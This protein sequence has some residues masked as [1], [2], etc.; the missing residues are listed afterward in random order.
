MAGRGYSRIA[1]AA[2]A[3]AMLVVVAWWYWPQSRQPASPSPPSADTAF[4]TPKASHARPR[5]RGDPVRIDSRDAPGTGPDSIRCSQERLRRLQTRLDDLKHPATPDQV[6]QHVLLTIM[7][8]LQVPDETGPGRVARELDAARRRWPDNL[9]LAWLS[10]QHCREQSGCDHDAAL[11][12]LLALDPENAAA[13]LLAMQTARLRGDDAGYGRLLHRAAA[14]S[15]YD[16]RIGVIFLQARVLLASMPQPT[17]CVD[18]ANAVELTRLLGHAPTTDDWAVAGAS[19][20]ESALGLPAY[21]GLS[22]CN[23]S[24]QPLPVARRRDCIALLARVADGDTLLEQNLA[25]G[26]LI[27][28]TG[29]GPGHAQLRE[30]YRRLRWLWTQVPPSGSPDYSARIWAD[31]EVAAL[32]ELAIAQGRW[33]PPPDWLPNDDRSRALIVSGRLPPE[34]H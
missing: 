6:I 17:Y 29:D 33:P 3:V 14:S 13:W 22:G 12:H 7:L 19:L 31:G 28:L 25:L 21:G 11:R 16:P 4:A 24:S 2:I 34:Q 27:R 23:D 30:R 5:R 10:A 26:L 1:L 32:R 9:D 20:L 15:I 8:S 18:Q